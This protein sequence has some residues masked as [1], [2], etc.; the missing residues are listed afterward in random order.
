M[1]SKGF[2]LPEILEDDDR[3]LEIRLRQ[4]SSISLSSLFLAAEILGASVYRIN[5]VSFDTEEGQIAHYTVVFK[6]E[7]KDFSPLLVF[8]TMF[9][10]AYTAIGIYK[11]L[12]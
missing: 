2:K 5:T 10:E 8:L 7:G 3:Y 4:D 1:V 6:D 12:E 9:T 11:N